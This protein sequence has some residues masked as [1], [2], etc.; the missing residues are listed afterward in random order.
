[1]MKIGFSSSLNDRSKSGKCN[2]KETEMSKRNGKVEL[3]K[4]SELRDKNNP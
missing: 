3:F 4:N 1:M 2:N